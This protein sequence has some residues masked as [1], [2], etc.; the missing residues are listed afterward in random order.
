VGASHLV[1]ASN[2]GFTSTLPLLPCSKLRVELNR[3]FKRFTERMEEIAAADPTAASRGGF[4]TFDVP[5]RDL[6]FNGAPLKEMV[7]ILPCG[8][9]LV[10]VADKPVRARRDRL[11]VSL[12][13]RQ[14]QARQA[15]RSLALTERVAHSLTERVARSLAH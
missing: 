11:L 14:G 13:G 5:M 3:A 4:R 12:A 10:S 9:C 6:A 15:R 7:P 2:V 1:A 8:E